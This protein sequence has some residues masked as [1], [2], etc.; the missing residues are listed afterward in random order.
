MAHRIRL[1]LAGA[2]LAL[3]AATLTAAP[4]HA[5]SLVTCESEGGYYDCYLPSG[6]YGQVWYYDGVHV[7][8]ADN[9][10]SIGGSCVVG[11]K[12]S[13]RVTFDGGGRSSTSFTCAA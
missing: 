5:A 13:V 10:S 3:G 6:Y 11:T 12:H 9:Y 8:G 1:A 4:A 2:A 7:A